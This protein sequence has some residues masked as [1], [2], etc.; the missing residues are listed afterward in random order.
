MAQE[1]QPGGSTVIKV[2]EGQLGIGVP[3]DNT[4]PNNFF[5]NGG[6]VNFSG[7]F[8]GAVTEVFEVFLNGSDLFLTGD[9]GSNT[10]I[11]NVNADGTYTAF[12]ID[13]EITNLIQ[14]DNDGTGNY[15][16]MTANYGWCQPVL[17]RPYMLGQYSGGRWQRLTCL[18][19]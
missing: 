1:T 15:G 3:Y 12:G 14:W 6:L 11:N 18:A 17:P 5:N 13:I 2:D 19:R 16:V 4:A 8:T 9:Q 7:N 10:I